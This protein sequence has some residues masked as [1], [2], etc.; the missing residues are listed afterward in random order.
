MASPTSL[1]PKSWRPSSTY[2]A[3]WLPLRLS[4][5]C[6]PRRRRLLR[7][8]LYNVEKLSLRRGRNFVCIRSFADCATTFFSLRF[9]HNYPRRRG[10]LYSGGTTRGRKSNTF[11]IFVPRGRHHAWRG[12]R[13][14]SVTILSL[15]PAKHH[16]HRLAG[17][18]RRP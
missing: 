4:P 12:A 3:Q 10:T 11:F 18:P 17:I 6:L 15:P 1:P 9:H 7:T 16:N 14:A 8:C 13:Y 5:V 2:R